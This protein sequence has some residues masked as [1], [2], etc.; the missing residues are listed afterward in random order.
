MSITIASMIDA[1]C[2]QAALQPPNRRSQTPSRLIPHWNPAPGP[3][4]IPRWTRLSFDSTVRITH[5][6]YDRAE[7]V[8]PFAEPAHGLVLT[9][10]P[11]RLES[12]QLIPS[13][14]YQL[15]P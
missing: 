13:L 6:V 9:F 1:P 12:A 7:L 4:L 3:R 15:T 2:W 11:S 5:D 8:A 10:S 14:G